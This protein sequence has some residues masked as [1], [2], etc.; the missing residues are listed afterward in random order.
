MQGC[1]RRQRQRCQRRRG[2]GGAREKHVAGL[3]SALGIPVPV[4]DELDAEEEAAAHAFQALG[5]AEGEGAQEQNALNAGVGTAPTPQEVAP[6]QEEVAAVVALCREE[7][8][9]G[10]AQCEAQR[11]PEGALPPCTGAAAG[12]ARPDDAVLQRYVESGAQA[13]RTF[14]ANVK[15]AKQLLLAQKSMTSVNFARA[16]H[17]LCACCHS[18]LLRFPLFALSPL[19]LPPR[20]PLSYAH[21]PPPSSLCTGAQP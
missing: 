19:P 2:G 11:H 18:H 1:Q 20:A 4:G 14:L 15:E 16:A 3:L 9:A 21:P 13:L 5:I 12:G 10:A 17:N 8:A 6:T 7:V